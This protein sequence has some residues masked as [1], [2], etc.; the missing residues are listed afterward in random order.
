[1][2]NFSS[3][4]SEGFHPRD[5]LTTGV[6]VDLY[7]VIWSQVAAF[8]YGVSGYNFFGGITHEVASVFPSH[9]WSCVIEN[10]GLPIVLSHWVGVVTHPGTQFVIW[11]KTRSMTQISSSHQARI[12]VF[13]N[14]NV[15]QVAISQIKSR[16]PQ[17][18]QNLWNISLLHIEMI[19]GSKCRFVVPT[20][21]KMFR[22]FAQYHY[23]KALQHHEI[24]H[25]F[26][27][28]Q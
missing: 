25:I 24:S 5:R 4:S 20:L 26:S 9:Q 11:S 8:F 15:L 12:R 27:N 18:F 3:R 17:F 28:K 1:V 13:P 22:S 16:L 14:K 10:S 6:E 2:S 23:T 21:N 7:D 19:T